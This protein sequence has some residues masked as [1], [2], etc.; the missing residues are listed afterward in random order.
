MTP[1]PFFLSLHSSIDRQIISAESLKPYGKLNKGKMRIQYIA[2]MNVI[3]KWMKANPSIRLLLVGPNDVVDGNE[4]LVMGLLWSLM[5]FYASRVNGAESKDLAQAMEDF[6]RLL[7][8]AAPGASASTSTSGGA[9]EESSAAA[10]ER[11]AAEL[12][13]AKDAALEDA[14]ALQVKVKALEPISNERCN[15]WAPPHPT[16][17]EALQGNTSV[18]GQ[19]P[20]GAQRT[21]PQALYELCAEAT[22]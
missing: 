3:F 1:S 17:L 2:N 13:A 16:M 18:V 12:Q 11:L 20:G 4:K 6:H 7:N 22:S 5:E 14:A 9:A 19:T 8:N 21:P 15:P 10:E